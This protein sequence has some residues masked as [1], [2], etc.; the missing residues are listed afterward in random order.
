MSSKCD[1]WENI[2][3]TRFLFGVEVVC[4][5]IDAPEFDCAVVASG[6]ETGLIA[7]GGCRVTGY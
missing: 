5:V 4:T 3:V 2:E 1:L 7:K 6:N